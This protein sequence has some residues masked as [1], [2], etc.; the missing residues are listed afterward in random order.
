MYSELLRSVKFP[1][2]IQNT[3]IKTLLWYMKKIQKKAKALKTEFLQIFSCM[4]KTLIQ[5]R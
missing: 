5:T 2:V 1:M 4:L 3:D